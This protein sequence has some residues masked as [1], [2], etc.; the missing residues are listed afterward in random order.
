MHINKEGS[1]VNTA[2][3]RAHTTVDPVERTISAIFTCAVD[4]VVDVT[5]EATS[6]Q[7]TAAQI[8][9]TVTIKRLN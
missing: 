4:D 9:T 1:P 8:G 5:Y 3:P 7:T 6:A 2:N